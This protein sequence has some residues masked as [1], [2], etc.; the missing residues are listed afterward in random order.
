[1]GSPEL[2]TFETHGVKVVTRLAGRATRPALLLI[3]G[4]P[5]SWAS[6]RDVMLPL[7]E[8]C[9]VIAPDLPGF[10]NSGPMQSP[11][12]SRFADVIEELLV[13]LRVGAVHLYLHDYGA[14]VGFHLATRDPRRIR[15]LIVQNANAHHSGMGQQWAATRA[16]WTEPTPD[17]EREATGHLTADGI[18][19]QYTGGVPQDIAA[20]MD[21][22][23][24]T[25]DWRVMSLPGRLQT[26]R[27]LVLDYRSHVARFGEIAKY[28][29]HWQPPAL[30]LWG[31]HDIF[32]RS[33]RDRCLDEGTAPHGSTHP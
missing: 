18:R 2:L 9:F 15:S 1:M 29:A 27:E 8:D 14:A 25:E 21:P 20:Q 19:D 22:E 28:L 24:W 5:A 12:F 3:H 17:R 11:S 7:A 26:Q 33:R 32:L 30:M 6:F 31:R 10:G 16:Y 13:K 23:R 4:F